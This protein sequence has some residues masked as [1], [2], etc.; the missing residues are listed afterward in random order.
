VILAGIVSNDDARANWLWKQWK[1]AWRVRDGGADEPTEWAGADG[2]VD[3][4]EGYLGKRRGCDGRWVTST[5][6]TATEPWT[7]SGIRV[8]TTLR[9]TGAADNVTQL[10]VIK[11]NGRSIRTIAVDSGQT[12]VILTVHANQNS[13]IVA[14]YTASS[15]TLDRVNYKSFWY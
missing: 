2:L 15:T 8:N 3:R 10:T 13:T 5:T 9:S 4:L 7:G 11:V 6:R 1:E 12:T 14:S